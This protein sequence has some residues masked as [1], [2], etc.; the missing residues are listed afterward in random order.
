MR[1]SDN[2]SSFIEKGR[3]NAALDLSSFGAAEAILNTYVLDILMSP[4]RDCTYWI[5][6]ECFSHHVSSPEM[7]VL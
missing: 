3:V 2:A 5:K 4:S 7:R 6:A 1:P